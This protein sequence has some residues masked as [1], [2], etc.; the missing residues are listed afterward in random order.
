MMTDM[1]IDAIAQAMQAKIVATQRVAKIGGVAIMIVVGLVAFALLP[2]D[3][4]DGG[5]KFLIA[6]GIGLASFMVCVGVARVRIN[7]LIREFERTTGI[8]L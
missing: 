4:R 3:G 5:Y 8:K 1:E 7:G 2:D 6:C